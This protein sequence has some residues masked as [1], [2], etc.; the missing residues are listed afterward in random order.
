[1]K[2]AHLNDMAKRGEY[3]YALTTP[4]VEV[5]GQ[6]QQQRQ[7]QQR[8]T[9]RQSKQLLIKLH[10]RHST[11]ADSLL[12]TRQTLLVTSFVVCASHFSTR[13]E[14]IMEKGLRLCGMEERERRVHQ[15]CEFNC[16]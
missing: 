7:G 1:M 16:K 9:T 10:G 13:G 6:P 11:S 8:M 2:K 14:M 15:E 4:S 3:G 5:A 12:S